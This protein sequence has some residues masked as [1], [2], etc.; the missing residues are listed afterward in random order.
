MGKQYKLSD[1][2][3]IHTVV[4]EV[5]QRYQKPHKNTDIQESKNAT[6]EMISQQ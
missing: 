6:S 5:V 1:H 4:A 2:A 3:F